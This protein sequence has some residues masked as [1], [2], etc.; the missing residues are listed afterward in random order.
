MASPSPA[1][2]IPS[3]SSPSTVSTNAVCFELVGDPSSYGTIGWSITQRRNVY[4]NQPASS[5]TVTATVCLLPGQYAFTVIVRGPTGGQLTAIQ[6]GAVVFSLQPLR[7]SL[8]TLTIQSSYG[9]ASVGSK[10]LTLTWLKYEDGDTVA[11]SGAQGSNAAFYGL[12]GLLFL[13]P[14]TGFFV[15]RWARRPTAEGL[16]DVILDDVLVE[17]PVFTEARPSPAASPLPQLLQRGCVTPP[18]TPAVTEAAC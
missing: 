4:A 15:W 3:A 16:Q 12:L 5:T 13:L 17:A 10:Q 1:Q 18:P 8:Y 11:D 6:N 14:I 2:G 9:A 7:T